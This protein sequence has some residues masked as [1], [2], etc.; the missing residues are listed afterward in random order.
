MLLAGAMIDPG[1]LNIDPGGLHLGGLI[2]FA[3][4]IAVA[5]PVIGWP[6]LLLSAAFPL[7]G[8]SRLRSVVTFWV[9][10]SVMATA[11]IWYIGSVL[12]YPRP[13]AQIDPV[14]HLLIP[15]APKTG[16]AIG[17]F[18]LCMGRAIIAARSG[19]PQ[20]R[21]RR[22]RAV[23]DLVR[24]R[25]AAGGGVVKIGPTPPS[26]KPDSRSV[27]SGRSQTRLDCRHDCL[28]NCLVAPFGDGR[29]HLLR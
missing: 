14:G 15:Y 13:G 20:R 17:L 11:V 1:G 5:L 26:P 27:R 21:D 3:A 23:P 19:D 16:L 4:I 2:T 6:S 29:D 8:K 22:W 9:G 25:L 18:A 10:A 7:A 28:A 12:S 24:S